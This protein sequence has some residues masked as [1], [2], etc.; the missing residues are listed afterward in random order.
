MFQSYG[1][2]P[3]GYGA[4]VGP[5]KFVKAAVLGPTADDL[6]KKGKKR[7]AAASKAM[8]QKKMSNK[9]IAKMLEKHTFLRDENEDL[10]KAFS[11]NNL[12][13]AHKVWKSLAKQ[14]DKLKRKGIA[15]AEGKTFKQVAGR[16]Y[17]GVATLGASELGR[18]MFKKKISAARKKRAK[19]YLDQSDA[20]QKLLKFWKSQ[21]V[22]ETKKLKSKKTSELTASQKKMVSMIAKN[23]ADLD[24]I[25]KEGSMAAETDKPPTKEE[26]AKEAEAEAAVEAEA[27]KAAVDAAAKSEDPAAVSAPVATESDVAEAK[28][29][30]GA[31]GA[32]AEGAEG[33][34]VEKAEGG[35][36][37]SGGLSTNMKIGIAAA[38]IGVVALLLL[39]K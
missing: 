35:S 36:E 21:F 6:K 7:D 17:L 12:E 2:S 20:A 25:S 23:Q 33:T 32:A 24:A 30:E 19:A 39:R 8:K 14:R 4:A 11:T 18:L 15:A 29:S 9:D 10:A 13:L 26:A 5:G 37:S 28:S 3:S 38:G 27:P 16:T 1:F 34:A 22:D 31:E